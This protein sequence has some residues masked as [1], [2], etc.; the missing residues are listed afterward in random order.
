M[1]IQSF[2]IQQVYKCPRLISKK[3]NQTDKIINYWLHLTNDTDIRN[4]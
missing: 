4:S 3:A 2:V 1:H